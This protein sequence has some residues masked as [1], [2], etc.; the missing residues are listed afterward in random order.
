MSFTAVC[1][2]T[3]VTKLW[4][5]TTG[6]VMPVGLGKQHCDKMISAASLVDPS[7]CRGLAKVVDSQ[8]TTDVI[9]AFS[10]SLTRDCVC[11]CH[12]PQALSCPRWP[13]G[14]AQLRT[15]NHLLRR[16]LCQMVLTWELDS[17]VSPLLTP[18]P[19]R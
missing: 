2:I 12:R 7:C 1:S 5:L 9:E 18:I 11:G 6:S 13:H 10:F 19:Q 16:S 14:K 17:L 4:T 8:V 15:L 3:S